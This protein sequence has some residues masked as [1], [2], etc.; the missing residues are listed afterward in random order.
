MKAYKCSVC[1]SGEY[2]THMQGGGR[3]TTFRKCKI[4]N[5][6]RQARYKAI[7]RMQ[8]FKVLGG[9]C[10]GCGIDDYKVLCVD[11]VHANGAEERKTINQERLYR[12]IRD[13]EADL[14][15]YQA[16]CHNCNYLKR[17]V[18]HPRMWVPTSLG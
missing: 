12:M 18:D 6:K 17:L 8:V 3:K 9:V 1:G 2:Y 4:C 11:H 14:S 16:L 15:E 5:S 7:L 10:N 13:G